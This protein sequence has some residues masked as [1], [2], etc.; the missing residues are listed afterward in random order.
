MQRSTTVTN[1]LE[2]GS[3]VPMIR[4]RGWWLRT[5]GF[6]EGTKVRIEV[7]ERKLTLTVIEEVLPQVAS[8]ES[9]L[10]A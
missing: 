1:I 2:A 4:L 6:C 8:L 5:A 7:R 9:R 10:S 3:T